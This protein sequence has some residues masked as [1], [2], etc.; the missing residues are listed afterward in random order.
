MF[1][2]SMYVL[3]SVVLESG[4]RVRKPFGWNPGLGKHQMQWHIQSLQCE[5]MHVCMYVC[6]MYVC[7]YVCIFYMYVC[8]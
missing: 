2:T 6:T 4:E 1:Y 5:D 7:M 8:M 3:P